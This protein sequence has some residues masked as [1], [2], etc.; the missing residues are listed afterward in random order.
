MCR[1]RRRNDAR[2]KSAGLGAHVGAVV[3][4][5][6]QH[7]RR[8]EHVALR[9]MHRHAARLARKR[10]D[11]VAG[12][13]DAARCRLRN[14]LQGRC[15][16]RFCRTRHGERQIPVCRERTVCDA[17][18]LYAVMGG[19]ADEDVC[20]I[21]GGCRNADDLHLARCGVARRAR[22][23]LAVHLCAGDGEVVPA[24][25]VQPAIGGV[26]CA[27]PCRA[28]IDFKSRR[29]VLRRVKRD[30]IRTQLA[31]RCDDFRIRPAFDDAGSAPDGN[32][33][34][35]CLHGELRDV[36]GVTCAEADCTAVSISAY[37]RL[38]RACGCL[39]R[40]ARRG[41]FRKH[42]AAVIGRDV[43]QPLLRARCR[44]SLLRFFLVRV[45]FQIGTLLLLVRA[46]LHCIGILQ[47]RADVHH[48]DVQPNGGNAGRAV[49]RKLPDRLCIV[50][51]NVCR[52]ACMERAA[53]DHALDGG[54]EVVDRNADAR[55]D[56]TA[57]VHA[58]LLVKVQIV[59]RRDGDLLCR[60]LRFGIVLVLL[61][62]PEAAVSDHR[63][64]GVPHVSA[65]DARSNTP[66]PRRAE[67]VNGV[68]QML[69][70]ARTDK[71]LAL[72]VRVGDRRPR[73]VRLGRTAVEENRRADARADTIARKP[74]GERIC[75]EACQIVRCD[76]KTAHIHL[77]VR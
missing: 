69:L 52:L 7:P 31:A 32:A 12:K 70:V 5:E 34:D 36:H 42:I 39:C 14:A 67:A 23:G 53:R 56:S 72:I 2:R 48:H 43:G 61:D 77:T 20:P 28:L 38:L 75:M 71:R 65:A 63:F 1:R 6:R 4:T 58:A 10:G 46:F 21:A 19:I 16:R 64:D 3:R 54:F 51:R 47:I 62:R 11:A 60:R 68:R 49:C 76:P 15:V 41:L 50:R 27:R 35:T 40:R 74:L 18:G 9:E 55:T 25:H 13:G 37:V 45:L 26:E 17:H 59:L 24:A 44:I 30:R 22:D 66:K 29:A 8:R 73:N 57:A 33:A